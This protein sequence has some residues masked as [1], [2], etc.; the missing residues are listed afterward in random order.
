MHG[1][2]EACARAELLDQLEGRAHRVEGRDFQHLHI[3][4]PA[5]DAFVL[6]L[7]EQRFQHGA[8]LG[9]VLCEDVSFLDVVGAFAARQRWLVEGDVADEV[10]G[11]EIFAHL[12]Q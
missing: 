9:A 7:G 10:E 12:F 8:G 11:V 6:V 4:Q 3:V 2:L 1:S 5:D